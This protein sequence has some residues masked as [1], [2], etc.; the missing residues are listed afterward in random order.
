M[1]YLTAD[2]GSTYTKLTAIDASK[3]EIVGTSTA[4][5]TIETDVMEGYN[6]ALHQLEEKI[7]EFCYDQLLCC[8]SA[9]GGLAMVALGLVPELT[10]KAAKMAASSA[11]AKVVRTYAFEISKAEQA[12]IYDINPDLVLLCGGTDGGNKEVIV[13]NA[14]KLC[15]IDRSF[16]VIVA[17]NKS[18]SSDIESIFSDSEKDYVITENVM[19]EFNKLNIE[20]AKQ[21]IKELFISKIVDAKGLSKIQNL[22]NSEII[23]TP[24]AVLNGCELLSKGTEQTEGLGDLMAIDIGGAT[25]DVYSI[26]DGRPTFDNVMIK[27][28]PEP[29]NKR[30]VEGDLGMRYSLYSLSNEIDLNALSEEIKVDVKDIV[31]WIEICKTSPNTLAKKN[32]IYQTIEE[33]LAKYALKIAVERHVGKMESTFTP[34]GQMYIVSGKDL[35]QVN[36]IIG[37]GGVLVNSINPIKILDA[38]KADKQNPMLLKP[39]Q[40][41]YLLDRKYI[42]ASMGLLSA[43]DA[44]LALTIM[45]RE[46]T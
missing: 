34:F 19:P 22:T 25:T 31:K 35:T 2:F 43:V 1:K 18:A 4:F 42:F 36:L 26:S 8:S 17:G 12:E 23:P 6:F 44:E 16:S 11:G 15:E 28:L 29:F 5:T 21:K 45:K 13:N 41:N 27:G 7:G 20:P 9:A 33:G 46:I 37:I 40:P 38:A 32:S 39:K 24:L 3:S 14:K 30:T 10:S